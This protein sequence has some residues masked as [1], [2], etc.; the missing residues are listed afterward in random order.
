V[1]FSKAEFLFSCKA[2]LCFLCLLWFLF[3]DL[4]S[5]SEKPQEAQCSPVGRNR[6]EENRG[7]RGC[8]GFRKPVVLRAARR[9]S[10]VVAQ[11]AQGSVA[12]EA[13]AVSLH[14]AGFGGVRPPDERSRRP[15]A[16]PVPTRTPAAHEGLDWRHPFDRARPAWLAVASWRRRQAERH[17]THRSA[18]GGPDRCIL[19]C[20]SG[21]D[22]RSVVCGSRDS[23]RQDGPA[24]RESAKIRVACH[25]A[26]WRSG[27]HGGRR[28]NR[29]KLKEKEGKAT[30]GGPGSVRAVV[31]GGRMTQ[32]RLGDFL[33]AYRLA[34][35]L[36]LCYSHSVCPNLE[37]EVL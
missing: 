8:H 33:S 18:W 13:R 23:A 34:C 10:R 32:P 15:A 22:V 5:V 37:T 12:G 31:P 27:R 16:V 14:A 4:P 3:K 21:G 29:A 1:E 26:V 30:W 35:I 19:P 6:A 36:H 11:N 9:F 2:F 20:T 24:G 28:S 25:S 7:Y 17:Q